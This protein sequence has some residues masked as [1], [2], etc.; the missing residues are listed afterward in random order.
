MKEKVFIAFML[1][2][3]VGISG[4][5]TRSDAETAGYFPG[6]NPHGFWAAL[7]ETLLRLDEPSLYQQRSKT[8]LEPY[9]M[10]CIQSWDK[11][12]FIRAWK[13]SRGMRV[14]VIRLNCEGAFY[15]YS[16]YDET[17]KV[18]GE[19]WDKLTKTVRT[20]GFW[21]MPTAEKIM[22]LDGEDWLLEAEANGRYHQVHRWSPS[23]HTEQ[24]HLKEFQEV[25]S[26]FFT[27]SKL[28]L[29]EPTMVDRQREENQ[30]YSLPKRKF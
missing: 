17:F 12:F 29:R 5:K 11:P 13:D 18:S 10:V 20:S 23:V 22:G 30:Q 9:R 25:C 6:E 28:K 19:Q 4:C 16:D 3:L 14:R 24:R 2:L 27:L 26:Y 1:V 21:E 7:D 8:D 15:G